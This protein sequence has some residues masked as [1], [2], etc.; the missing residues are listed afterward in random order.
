MAEAQKTKKTKKVAPKKAA[1]KLAETVAV[2]PY[3][4]SGIILGATL[5]G[6]LI[7]VNILSST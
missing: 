6:L 3:K 7:L 1:P 2:S 4:K 5:V